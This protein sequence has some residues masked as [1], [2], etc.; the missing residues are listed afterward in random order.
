MPLLSAFPCTRHSISIPDRKTFINKRSLD[1]CTAIK[2]SF[3]R[4]L[5]IQNAMAQPNT[6]SAAHATAQE[7]L[8]NE[9]MRTLCDERDATISE[10]QL[11]LVHVSTG[12][13]TISRH[14]VTSLPYVPRECFSLESEIGRARDRTIR[15]SQEDTR[16]RK[17]G[18]R[19]SCL[20][21]SFRKQAVCAISLHALC[22]C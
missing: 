4:R 21:C 13:P 6:P 5:V 12:D 15:E 3:S 8:S 14:S 1:L 9:P 16:A 19:G 22:I 7:V 2:A 17:R 10:D 20:R 11:C 18:K